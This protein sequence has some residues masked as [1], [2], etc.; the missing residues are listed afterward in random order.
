MF[1]TECPRF[2]IAVRNLVASRDLVQNRIDGGTRYS[3]DLGDVR[4]RLASLFHR[5]NRSDVR[6]REPED[7]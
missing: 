1:S 5:T 6:R 2:L 3:D 7:I 4:D